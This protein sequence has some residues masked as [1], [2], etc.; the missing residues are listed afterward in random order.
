MISLLLILVM[1]IIG[2]ILLLT[3]I[4][5]P[6]VVLKMITAT[7]MVS[8]AQV[9]SI[10]LVGVDK[11]NHL[12]TINHTVMKLTLVLEVMVTDTHTHTVH[13]HTATLVVMVMV[14]EILTGTLIHMVELHTLTLLVVQVVA[15]KNLVD[16]RANA[17]PAAMVPSIHSSLFLTMVL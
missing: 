3:P 7:H 16:A 14:T 1:I 9:K 8:Q 6:N 11:S 12:T 10:M 5:R 4:M 17:V 13:T 15:V 2:I